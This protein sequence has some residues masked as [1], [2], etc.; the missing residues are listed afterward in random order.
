MKV[1]VIQSGA[2]AISPRE[3]VR[4][5]RNDV[6]STG[7]KGLSDENLNRLIELELAK[8]FEDSEVADDAEVETDNG[9]EYD[10]ES[11][12]DKNELAEYALDIYEVKLNKQKS[13][14]NMISD[15][16]DAIKEDLENDE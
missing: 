2:L 6:L 13:I 14:A 16:K 11:M 9:E 8:S 3:I 10:F 12:T 1:I 4:F 5:A 7:D 15:L